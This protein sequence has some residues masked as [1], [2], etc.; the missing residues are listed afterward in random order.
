MGEEN[1][2]WLH[3]MKI[4]L[5]DKK[6]LAGTAEV[7]KATFIRQTMSY[8]W[9]ECNAGAYPKS[10]IYVVENSKREI[11]GYIH[12]CQKSGFRPEVVLELEQLAVHPTW[13]GKGLGTRLIQESLPQVQAQLKSRN[14]AVKHIVVTT[15]A[16][17]FAQEL[18]KKTLNAEVEATMSNL[19]SADEVF[20]I[21]RNIT[22]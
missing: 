14:A 3:N 16:D 20:M 12:W 21:S 6:D 11:V 9:I 8:E 18:Y 15:R 13:Q 1:D 19:Y 5:F 4:R 2:K 17:N 7:H 22:I 10:Q